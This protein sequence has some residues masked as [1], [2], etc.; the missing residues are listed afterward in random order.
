M[1]GKALFSCIKCISQDDQCYFARIPCVQLVNL[2]G[3]FF[4]YLQ[5]RSIKESSVKSFMKVKGLKSLYILIDHND[6][7][8]EEDTDA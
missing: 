1:R 3:A 7:I 8:R 2:G 4:L 5:P 6:P